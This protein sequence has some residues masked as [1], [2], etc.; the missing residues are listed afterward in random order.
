MHIVHWQYIIDNHCILQVPTDSI[1]DN[2]ISVRSLAKQFGY[3]SYGSERWFRNWYHQSR[4]SVELSIIKNMAS[5]FRMAVFQAML[6][7]CAANDLMSSETFVPTLDN[8]GNRIE[9]ISGEYDQEF[10]EVRSEIQCSALCSKNNGSAYNYYT[11]TKRCKIFDDLPPILVG[12]GN[13]TECRTKQVCSEFVI[14]N[15]LIN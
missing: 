1:P 3:Q 9:C 7:L 8:E 11:A 13:N 14:I 2:C 10:E 12:V 5:K 4:Y 6:Y 15:K